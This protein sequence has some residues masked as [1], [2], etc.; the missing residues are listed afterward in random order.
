MMIGDTMA[1][2]EYRLFMSTL[3]KVFARLYIMNFGALPASRHLVANWRSFEGMKS[4]TRITI[5]RPKV[6]LALSI[7]LL[8]ILQTGAAST[9]ITKYSSLASWTK[10]HDRESSFG[11]SAA[12]AAAHA[13]A[14]HEPTRFTTGEWFE[15]VFT[16]NA[17]R[18][19]QYRSDTP[20]AIGGGDRTAPDMA[21]LGATSLG[22]T[23]NGTAPA[24]TQDAV[25]LAPTTGGPLNG[26]AVTTIIGGASYGFA[27]GPPLSGVFGPASGGETNVTSPH[28]TEV[29]HATNV[30]VRAA[31]EI[32]PASALSAMTLL[33]GGITVW[34]QRKGA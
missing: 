20:R 1:R 4:D 10:A 13:S 33:L 8:G 6:L 29:P 21:T 5:V 28:A 2:S 9:A 25:R 17:F 22:A 18:G 31:P 19:L 27:F 11:A 30:A 23:T 12:A 24:L 15:H 7:G 32:D 14:V 34:R 16:D 26:S 3:P